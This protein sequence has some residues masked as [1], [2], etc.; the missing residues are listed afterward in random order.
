MT[1]RPHIANAAAR[2]HATVVLPSR[3]PLL[4][5]MRIFVRSGSIARSTLARSARN[6]S[7]ASARVAGGHHEPLGRR[8]LAA[9]LGDLAQQ[10]Q[11]RGALDVLHPAQPPVEGL[12]GER[13]QRADDRAEQDPEHDVAQRL[14]ADL[15]R[16]ARVDHRALGGGQRLQH[17][18]ALALLVERLAERVGLR[19]LVLERGDLPVEVLHRLAVALRG[20]LAP[21]GEVGLGVRRREPLRGRRGRT[22]AMEHEQA[23]LLVHRDLRVL[24]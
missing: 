24:R 19:V 17:L 1:V 6:A 7:T 18:E 22:L 20:E 3:G 13:E 12:D 8:A 9:Q 14:R 2:L 4:V 11:A 5:T 10:P 15:V 16:I 21:V 23:R